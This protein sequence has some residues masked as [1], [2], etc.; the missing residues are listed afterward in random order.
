MLETEFDAMQKNT[1]NF[2]AVISCGLVMTLC[3]VSTAIAANES[4][5]VTMFLK[6]P[7]LITEVNSLSFPDTNI[8][9]SVSV[10]TEPEDAMAT[11]FL[12]T[13]IANA[14]VTGSIVEN[15]I[16]LVTGGSSV[17]EQI[18]V[19]QFTTGGDMSSKGNA[20]FSSLG[21]LKNLRI[22][23][24]ANIRAENVA[25]AYSGTATFRLIY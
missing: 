24:T 11:T 3:S 10:V 6:R 19:D 20:V 18:L 22:G 21:I 15:S 17:S 8:G 7:L 16:T 1:L 4:F 14:A 9:S 25:G 12:A 2:L 23:A 13:G 5:S